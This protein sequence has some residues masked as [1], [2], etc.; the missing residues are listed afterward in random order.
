PKGE[1]KEDWAILRALSE[2]LGAKLPYDSLDQ[3]RAK[4]FADHP[5]FGRVDYLPEGPAD[6]DFAAL[7]KKG[8]V[9]DDPFWSGV[10]NFYLT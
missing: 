9:S 6:V 2:R 5:T 7:G 4:L 10:K 3:L 1:A 8:E